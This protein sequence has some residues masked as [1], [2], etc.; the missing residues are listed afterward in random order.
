MTDRERDQ[1]AHEGYI[2]REVLSADEL[3]A[4]R[5]A[6][7]ALLAQP[8]LASQR[9]FHYLSLL[10]P[11]LDAR[12]LHHAIPLPALM[13]TVEALLGPDLRLDNAALLAAE[14]LQPVETG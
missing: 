2:I 7:D 3:A 12:A 8:A 10:P 5:E 14:F 1:F 13:E 4:L 11:A 6:A 9:K